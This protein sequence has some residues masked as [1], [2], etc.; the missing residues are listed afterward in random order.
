MG[1]S[2]RRSGGRSGEETLLVRAEKPK[3]R[4]KRAL[5][6]KSLVVLAP[7][8]AVMFCLSWSGI[9]ADS[10]D[11][12]LPGTALAVPPERAALLWNTFAPPRELD[13]SFSVDGETDRLL[14]LLDAAGSTGP[15]KKIRDQ[16]RDDPLQMGGRLGLCDALEKAGKD[17]EQVSERRSRYGE[18]A[19]CYRILMDIFSFADILPDLA[20]PRR[21]LL[22]SRSMV[23]K[24]AGERTWTFAEGRPERLIDAIKYLRAGVGNGVSCTDTNEC[25]SAYA[26]LMAA[27]RLNGAPQ[28]ELEAT[29]RQSWKVPNSKTH[30]TDVWDVHIQLPNIRQ[31][32]FWDPAE[33]PWLA[34]IS[35]Q[36]RE[37]REELDRYIDSQEHPDAGWAHQPESEHIAG[38]AGAWNSVELAMNGQWR[39]ACSAHFPK[40][41]AMLRDRPELNP[42]AFRWPRGTEGVGGPGGRRPPALM[43]NVYQAMPGARVLPHFGT[44]GRL[45]A[46][47][48]LRVP[49]GKSI[50]RVGREKRPWVEG[51]WLLFDDAFEHDVVNE[52]PDARYVLA[53]AMLHPDVCGA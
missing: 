9:S 16:L 13:G 28:S 24:I 38:S 32:A 42:T 51:E 2:R 25:V 4:A 27:L 52:S 23:G 18:L 47:L 26:T 36:W 22:D 41:C 37:I 21:K 30:W 6:A 43:T 49:R 33:V 46:S 48:G 12:G 3:C 29:L 34:G 17:G 14:Q 40:T 8:A 15:A 5:I 31:K 11:D 45:V 53:V 20:D 1:T 7:G 44:H 19:T 50:L 10:S 35:A 39:R